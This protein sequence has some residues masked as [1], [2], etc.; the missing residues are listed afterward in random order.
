MK[1]EHCIVGDGVE[2][3]FS[4]KLNLFEQKIKTVS[5]VNMS[6]MYKLKWRGIDFELVGTVRRKVL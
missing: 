3:L 4:E 6:T 5:T 1:K 2:N